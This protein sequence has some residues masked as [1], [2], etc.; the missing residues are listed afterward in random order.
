MLDPLA[1]LGV[2]GNVLQVIDFG[3]QLVSEGNKIYRSANGT[4]EENRA[5]E[6]LAQ[7]LAVLAKGLSKSQTEWL[8]AHG[9][10][11]LDPDEVRLRNIC[12]RCAE[13]AVELNVI[14]QKLKVQDGTTHRRLKSYRQALISIWRKDQ[15]DAIAVRLERYQNELNT[16]VLIGLRKS[17]QAEEV[18]NSAQFSALDQQTKDLTLAVLDG[19]Q[20]L[21]ARLSDQAEVLSRIHDQT[22]RILDTIVAERKRSTS[23]LPTYDAVQE[24]KGVSSTPLHEAAEAGDALKVRQLLRSSGLDVNARDEHGCT[25]LH[26]ASS[27]EAVKRLLADRRIEKNIEDYEGRSA[28]HCA[29]LKR[30]L[31]VIKALL[32]ASIDTTLEDDRGK[33][34]AFYALECPAASWMLKYGHEVEGR[35]GDHLHNTGL[36]QMAWLGDI[37]GT[38][39]FLRHNADVNARNDWRESALTEAARHGS[40][41]IVET[42]IDNGAKVEITT[43]DEWTPLLQAVRDDR[44][45]VVRLLLRNGANKEAKLKNQNTVLGEACARGHLRIAEMLVEAGSNIETINSEK[46]TPLSTASYK[47]RPSFTR[48]LLSRGA[49]KEFKDGNGCT[50]VYLTSQRNHPK[51]LK[52]LLGNGANANTSANDGFTALIRA[53]Q[54]GHSECVKLL[55][56]YGADINVHAT[57]GSQHTALAEAAQHGRTEVATILLDRGARWDIGSKSGF[58][59]VSIAAANGQDAVLRFLVEH[60]A[61]IEQAGYS[62]RDPELSVTPLM[63]AAMNGHT[64][65]VGVLAELGAK[66]DAQDTFGRTALYHATTSNHS[67]CANMLIQHGA[68]LDIQTDKSETALMKAA[69]KGSEAIV[70]LLVEAGAN[71]RLRDWRG[72]TAWIFAIHWANDEKLKHLLNPGQ[73]EDDTLHRLQTERHPSEIAAYLNE[74]YQ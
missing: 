21:D 47:G 19:G 52:V 2:A 41:R 61:N 44:E 56:I 32:E 68:N 5:A 30:R 42:L 39:F 18:R 59:A 20:K 6:D 4:I 43:G 11:P 13:V 25:P 53:A 7:D 3:F 45:E 12:D 14:L 23:P 48:L 26:N 8:Q 27:G 66:L 37:E 72:C 1:A 9:D 29:V 34:A 73:D 64:N 16:H 50:P 54:Q 31:D 67:G 33:T 51:T 74:A 62:N 28:L 65:A 24:A 55:L 57:N 49:N 35:A 40:T 69:L 63:R 58:G 46:R 36:I 17:A 38:K 71:T 60:G 10:T 22:S 15:V 70:S